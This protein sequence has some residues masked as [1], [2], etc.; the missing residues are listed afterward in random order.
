MRLLKNKILQILLLGAFCLSS[1]SIDSKKTSVSEVFSEASSL[2][3]LDSIDLNP[4]D[5]LQA[6][7][8]RFSGD[9]FVFMNG[10]QPHYVTFWDRSENRVLEGVFKGEGPKE[11]VQFLPMQSNNKRRFFYADRMRKNVFSFPLDSSAILI[12]EEFHWGDSLARFTRLATNDD[13]NYYGMGVLIEGRI[14][15]F[16]AKKGTVR[17]VGEYPDMPNLEY[18]SSRHEA[19]LFANGHMCVHP[20][21]Q[22]VFVANCGMFDLYDCT[23]NAMSVHLKSL[24]LEYPKV[25]IL[26]SGGPAFSYKK[27][28][29]KGAMMVVCDE[30]YV[31][32]LYSL[33]TG[34]EMLTEGSKGDVI[35]VF[36]WDGNPVRQYNCGQELISITLDGNAMYGLKHDGTIL[37]R[38]DLLE[39][40][41]N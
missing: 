38:Y 21:R 37:Y 28:G 14:C 22:R 30:N 15:V 3:V 27:E 16:N 31:Y 35:L 4:L 23:E 8:M 34:E 5:M 11:V 25:Q 9:K 33:Q 40:K 10:Q 7:G 32:V 18:T 41:S 39:G 17:F 12:Q 13:E 20:Q 29:L 36:D 6:Y 2:T 24:Y 19:A 1:C 26:G